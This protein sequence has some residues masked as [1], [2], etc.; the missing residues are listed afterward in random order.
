MLMSVV[1]RML[2]CP[3]YLRHGRPGRRV[4][5]Q[6]GGGG[7]AGGDLRGRLRLHQVQRLQRGRG[8]LL[9]EPTV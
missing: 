1:R 6:G 8:I 4:H 7:Q 3:C 9:Q 5:P 2:P